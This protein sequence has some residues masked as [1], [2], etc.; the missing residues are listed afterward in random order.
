[1]SDPIRIVVADDAPPIVRSVVDAALKRLAEKHWAQVE[2][3]MKRQGFAPADGGI[4]VLPQADEPKT[5]GYRPSWVRFSTSV[6][7]ARLVNP[8]AAGLMS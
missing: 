8:R 3:V 7:S 1:M 2:D 4:L 5:P 6:D